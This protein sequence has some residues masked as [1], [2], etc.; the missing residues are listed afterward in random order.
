LRSALPNYDGVISTLAKNGSWWSSFRSKTQTIAD[1]PVEEIETFAARAYTSRNLGELGALAAAYARS[2]GDCEP[3]YALVEGL[4]ISDF[5][6]LATTEGMECLVLLAKAHTDI[7]QPRK[8]WMLWR[9]AMT[10]AQLMVKEHFS[11]QSVYS[12]NV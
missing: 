4:V 10:V 3:L 12:N 2:A 5:N 9:R 8:A 7:G 6:Y 11:W 1:S